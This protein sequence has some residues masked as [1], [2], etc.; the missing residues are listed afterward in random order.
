MQL[1]PLQHLNPL[2]IIMIKSLLVKLNLLVTVLILLGQAVSAQSKSSFILLDGDKLAALKKQYLSGDADMGKE[3]AQLM[4]NANKA[5]SAGPLSVTLRKT[6]IAPSGDAHDYVSQAPYWWPD[7]SK[8]DGKPYIRKDGERNPEIQQI[9]D[10]AQM[11]QMCNATKILAAAYYFTGKE[12]YA[13][14]A[15]AVLNTWFVDPATKMNPNLNYGQYIPGINDGRGIGI[16]ETRNLVAVPDAVAML[17][18]SK[19]LTPQ[20]S[21]GLQKWFTAYADWLQTSKN[22]TSE[23]D[24]LNNHGTNYDMQLVNFLIFT[25]NT[26]QARTIIQ[27]IS[28]PRIAVQFKPDGTQPLELARTKSWGYSCFNLEAWSRLGVMADK[29]GIDIWHI[30]TKDG[31]SIKKCIAWMLPYVL[32]EKEWTYQQI[33]P[34]D[35]SEILEVCNMVATKYPDMNFQRVLAMYPQHKLWML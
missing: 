9:H 15:A 11:V 17:Q 27:K 24:Q 26:E 5:L 28:I 10:D 30:E 14:K 2:G 3:V 32:K 22:G 12:E 18:G 19:S 35:Y 6:K 20:L 8:P 33:E 13:Q 34:I 4:T 1:I 16:I 29:L 7:P 21:E 23:H 25:G 31:K